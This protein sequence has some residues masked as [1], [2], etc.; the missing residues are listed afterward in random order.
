MPPLGTEAGLRPDGELLLRP[1]LAAVDDRGAYPVPALDQALVGQADQ[2][3]GRTPGSRSAW[4]STT[5]PSTPTSAT[6]H[7]R[8]KPI[9]A[10]PRACSTTGAPRRGRT[11]PTR[12][13]RTP[14]GG[15]PPCSRSIARRGGAAVAPSPAVIAAIGCWK[16][17]SLRVLTSQTTRR[18]RPARRCRSRRVLPHRQ[19]RSRTVMPGLGQPPRGDV[20]A[21]PPERPRRRSCRH[22][23]RHRRV[24]HPPPSGSGS[25]WTTRRLWITPSPVRARRSAG[26]GAQPGG[27]SSSPAA[28]GRSCS[29]PRCSRP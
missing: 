23:L 4:T 24:T 8:A 3:E 21:V 7:V 22:H 9:H 16:P 15:A 28:P 14:P 10:T 25:W 2:G 29:A 19:F 12:S 11:T 5:T 18:R 1:D 6:E 27:P 20:L 13:M 26:A 17:P